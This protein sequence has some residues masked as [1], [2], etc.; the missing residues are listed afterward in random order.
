MIIDVTSAGARSRNKKIAC[1]LRNRATIIEGDA[2]A[3]LAVLPDNTVQCVITSPPYWG[4]RDYRVAGQLGLEPNLALYIKSLVDVFSE[5]RRV[6]KPS[7]VVWLNLGD[8]YSSGNRAYRSADK[9]Y[10]YRALNVRPKTPSGIKPKDLVGIPWALAFALRADGWYLRT[11]IVWHKPNAM[12]ESVRD[13]PGRAHEYL[14]M[15]SKCQRYRFYRRR[16][17]ALGLGRDRTV[18][19]I[20]PRPSDFQGH[21]HAVFPKSLV[22]PCVLASTNK[23]D[24]VLDPFCGTATVGKVCGDLCRRFVGIDLNRSYARAAVDRL[25]DQTTWLRQIMRKRMPGRGN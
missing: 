8:V 2:R 20:A 7:G 17:F 5:V 6:L 16:L 25:G 18:W 22:E 11:E 14:F 15:L 23:S 12:P 13:R 21:H 19:S 9:K 10:P 3:V 4:T 1:S 24:L